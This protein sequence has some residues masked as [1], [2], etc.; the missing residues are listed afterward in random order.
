MIDFRL[1]ETDQSA[2]RANPGGGDDRPAA[3][4]ARSTR[5]RRRCRRTTLP[6]AEDFYAKLGPL[7]VG[8]P[9]DTPRAP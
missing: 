4:R 2:P 1:T 3:T 8:G 6:E 9:E 7:P 5:T